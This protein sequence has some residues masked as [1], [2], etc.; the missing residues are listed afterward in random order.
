MA[1][2]KRT[3]KGCASEPKSAVSLVPPLMWDHGATG[4]ANRASLVTEARGEMDVAT[5]KRVNPN[6]VTGVVR[7]SVVDQYARSGVISESHM[8]AANM[9]IALSE[10]HQ[11]VDPLSAIVIDKRCGSSD[12]QAALFDSRRNFHRLWRAIPNDCAAVLEVTV[13]N[14]L[15]I[16]DAFGAKI[17]ARLDAYAK[18]RVGLDIAAGGVF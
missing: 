12:P 16:D 8:Q 9:L 7:V 15:H 17:S 10:G 2:R 13:L 11:T 6:G 5:G 1:K 4:P 18:L 14:G 3:A